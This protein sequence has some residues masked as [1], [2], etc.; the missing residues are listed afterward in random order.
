ML[1]AE[2]GLAME[3]IRRFDEAPRRAGDLHHAIRWHF[4]GQVLEP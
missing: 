3:E 1:P 2:T 4:A